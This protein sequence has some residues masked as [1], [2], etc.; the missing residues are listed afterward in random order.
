MRHADWRS[1]TASANLH[2]SSRS[3][4]T[5]HVSCPYTLASYLPLPDFATALQRWSQDWLASQEGRLRNATYQTYKRILARVVLTIG[6]KT[7]HRLTP[8]LLTMFF[9]DLRKRG[10]G[11]RQL[12][13]CRNDLLLGKLALAHPVLLIT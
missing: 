10:V 11:D 7:L 1:T 8:S 4:R 9:S 12:P 3:S 5:P 2:K 13:K 6:A